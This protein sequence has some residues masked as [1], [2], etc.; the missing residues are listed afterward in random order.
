MNPII[1]PCATEA[2]WH[3]ERAKALGASEVAALFGV[4]P[5]MTAL[6]LW[7]KKKLLLAEAQEETERMEAGHFAELKIAPWYAK[8]TGRTVVEPQAFYHRDEEDL[9]TLG[10]FAV[11]V[12]H[13]TLPLQCTPDRIAL[14]GGPYIVNGKPAARVRVLQIKNVDRFQKDAW[15]DEGETSPP[16][17]IQIQVQCE[18]LCTGLRWGAIAADIGGNKLR[19]ADVE[20]HE[21]FMATLAS[22]ATEFWASL[23]TDL[24]PAPTG[25]DLATIKGF[26]PES[27]PGLSKELERPEL[28]FDLA[29]L[30]AQIGELEEQR[31]AIKATLQQEAGLAE[32]LTVQGR[33]VATWKTST[34]NEQAREARTTTQRTF[35][36]DNAIKKAAQAT[37]ERHAS[38]PAILPAD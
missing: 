35:L 7:S 20:R 27:M 15:D 28:I 3:A 17:W 33:K 21:G 25:D 6:Q 37:I 38:T 5:Y 31:D 24:A 22:K 8:R 23:S 1:I 29:R 18:L 12:R 4:H 2:D 13:P 16:L 10:A 34:R 11:I 26:Y 19:Y 30:Q 9:R 14:E 36:I 32:T